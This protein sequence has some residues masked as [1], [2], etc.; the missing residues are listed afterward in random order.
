MEIPEQTE[1]EI[2]KMKP[3]LNTTES[4]K[5]GQI[6]HPQIGRFATIAIFGLL[7]TSQNLQAQHVN[8]GALG[9]NQNSK[10]YFANGSDYVASSGYVKSLTFTN[11]STYAGYYQASSISFTALPQTLANAGPV[12]NAPALGSFI[13]IQLASVEGPAGGAFGFWQSGATNP[14]ISLTSGQKGSNLW[15]VSQNDGSPGSDPY[16]HI[17]G[18]RMTL[19]KPGLYKVG[20]KLFDTS[21]NGAGGGPI[22]TPSDEFP[23]YIQGG[24]SIASITKTGTVT[25]VTYG[26]ITNQNFSLEYHTN[27]LATGGW[28]AVG[29][30]VPGTDRLQSQSNTNASG[31]PRFYRVK[32]TAP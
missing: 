13:K 17:H 3:H 10:L 26:S 22:H 32:M 12:P 27:L 8:A 29:A 11:G 20:F 23:I 1:P 21:T 19:S 30:P 7:V 4:K 28:T 2:E 31:T 18:Q 5:L 9:T 14:T 24:L 16:G 15:V 6:I 25:E